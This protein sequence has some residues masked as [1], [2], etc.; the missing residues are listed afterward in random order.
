[1]R[2]RHELDLVRQAVVRLA[3]LRVQPARYGERFD[4]GTEPREEQR[5]RSLRVDRAVTPLVDVIRVNR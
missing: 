4:L 3:R 2:Q 5:E 1:M